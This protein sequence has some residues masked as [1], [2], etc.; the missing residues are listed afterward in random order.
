MKKNVIICCKKNY[1]FGNRD[2]LKQY[3]QSVVVLHIMHYYYFHLFDTL[4]LLNS[5]EEFAVINIKLKSIS[6]K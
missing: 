6:K 2:K 3:S 1:D 5:V 4:G